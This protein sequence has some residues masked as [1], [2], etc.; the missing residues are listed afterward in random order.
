MDQQAF[1]EAVQQEA[2]VAGINPML[3]LSGIEG[4]YTFREVPVQ[5]LNFALLDGLILTIFALRIGD[6][7]DVI[8]RQNLEAPNLQARIKAEWEL[9]ELNADDITKSGDAYLRSF[10]QMLGQS[11][12]VRRYH[13]KAL[14]VAAMEINH[15]HLHFGS[16]SIGA[17]TFEI[18]KGRLK[19]SMHLAALFGR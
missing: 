11:T 14:E 10:A 16:N 13:Q 3:L 1:I 6:S 4:L 7:F 12:P 19:D 15:A 9:A 17:I 2:Q 5:D 8:A 18:C